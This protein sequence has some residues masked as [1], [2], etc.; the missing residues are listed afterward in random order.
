ML[1]EGHFAA[2]LWGWGCDRTPNLHKLPRKQWLRHSS[3]L[4]NLNNDYS[5]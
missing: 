4:R 5:E 3:T 2:V 1:S